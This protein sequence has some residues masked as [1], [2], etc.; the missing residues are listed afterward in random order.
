EGTLD[1]EIE[2]FEKF[3]VDELGKELELFFAGRANIV[4]QIFD[5]L[6]RQIHVAVKIAE[7]HF[8]LDHPELVSV[9][10]GVRILRAKSWAKRVNLRQRAGESLGLELAADRQVG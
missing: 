5:H 2:S 9:P 1:D 8:R 7:G 4:D 10:R 3:L 6:L